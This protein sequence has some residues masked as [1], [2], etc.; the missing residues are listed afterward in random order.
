VSFAK[1][2][3]AGFGAGSPRRAVPAT[4]SGALTRRDDFLDE[5]RGDLGRLLATKLYRE[6]FGLR[7]VEKRN[8]DHERVHRSD[9]K[10]TRPARTDR[11]RAIS[12]IAAI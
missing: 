7:G 10:R 3:R 4:P 5:R 9:H 8:R 12:R 2:A 6:R 11:D 1:A